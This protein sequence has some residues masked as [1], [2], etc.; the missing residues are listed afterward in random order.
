LGPIPLLA[1]V[2]C[3]PR[4]LGPGAHQGLRDRESMAASRVPYKAASLSTS[5]LVIDQGTTEELVRIADVVDDRAVLRVAKQTGIGTDNRHPPTLEETIAEGA[6]EVDVLDTFVGVELIE[7]AGCRV[8][9]VD[10]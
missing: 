4:I 5:E 3:A 1:S 7:P 2:W 9:G 6:A 8:R 10:P